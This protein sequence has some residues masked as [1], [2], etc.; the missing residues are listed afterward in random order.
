MLL[1]IDATSFRLFHLSKSSGDIIFSFILPKGKTIYL[2]ETTPTKF[3]I[4]VVT[5]GVFLAESVS[6]EILLLKG[7]I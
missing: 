5:A 4:A 2:K 6:Q 3:V 7:L 1:G